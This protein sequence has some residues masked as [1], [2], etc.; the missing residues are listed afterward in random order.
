MDKLTGEVDC[1]IDAI[2]GRQSIDKK[3]SVSTEA[4]VDYCI[5]FTT[6]N[7]ELYIDKGWSGKNTD[8][9]KMQQLIADI[10]KHKIKKIIVYRLDRISRNIVDFGNLLTLFDEYGVQFVSSTENFDTSTPMGRAMVY[11]VMVFAQLE[12]ETIATRISDNYKFRCS[13][14]K[15]FMGG[16]VPFGYEVQ[17]TIVDGKKASVIV[18][19]EKAEILKEIFDKYSCGYSLNQIVHALNQDG[20]KTSLGNLWSS[21][22]LRRVL[23]NITPC[24]ADQRL[25]EY[26]NAYGYNI[27]NDPEDFDGKNGMC[28]FF[29]TKNRREQN[30]VKDQIAVIGIH[31]PLIE[32]DKFIKAQLL[33]ENNNVATK[34]PSKKSFLAG[35]LK[36]GECKYSFGL[37]TLKRGNKKYSYYVCR[38]RMSR[39]ICDNGLYIRASELEGDVVLK[40]TSYIKNKINKDVRKTHKINHKSNTDDIAILE[41]QIENLIDNIGKGTSNIDELL[42]NKITELQAKISMLKKEAQKEISNSVNQQYIMTINNELENFDRY[43]IE[44]KTNI[45]RKIIKCIT[46]YKDGTVEIEYLF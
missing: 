15:Y 42:T 36:C 28:L 8:R 18:P 25:Y 23:Q 14:G 24:V 32:S 1:K 31:E 33:L 35:L 17:K 34:K 22:T 44:G 43:D 2:Y 39:G 46:I 37:K 3:D 29:K 41:K 13:S 30:D 5:P 4:Q 11:I 38:G 45:I 26:L 10:K 6:G 9:P 19:G 21:N 20:E 27:T 16:G 40:C 12:R 7:Y